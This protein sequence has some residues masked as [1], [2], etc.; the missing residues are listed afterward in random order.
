[1][2]ARRACPQPGCAWRS[3]RTS[4][5]AAAS[6][7]RS[8]RGSTFPCETRRPT[9]EEP[10]QW[11]GSRFGAPERIRTPGLLIRSQTLYPTE[12]RVHAWC[13]AGR[14]VV[15]EREGFEPSIEVM[16]LYSLSRGAPSAARPP[17]LVA[18]RRPD[19]RVAE[20]EG[21]EP[22]VG[23]A[24]QRFSRPPLSTAQP[25]LRSA[26]GSIPAGQEGV[27]ARWTR[28]E[29]VLEAAPDRAS[30]PTPPARSGPGTPLLHAASAPRDRA[31]LETA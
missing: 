6:D 12:L 9:A 28:P 7:A 11:R 22:P 16:P 20:G 21:F 23:R 2:P 1:M 10:R 15:A 17:L 5:S 19:D 18:R 13:R 31:G 29:R 8:A 14:S 26:Q 27:N 25:T 24:P 4:C 30:Q 3:S